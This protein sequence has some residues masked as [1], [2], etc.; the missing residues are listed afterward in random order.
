MRPIA[1]SLLLLSAAY[2]KRAMTQEPT[3]ARTAAVPSE[4]RLQTA[5]FAL[6]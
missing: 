3:P 6:G 2:G 4:T 5:T 1:I